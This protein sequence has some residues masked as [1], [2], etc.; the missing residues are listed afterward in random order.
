MADSDVK[1][2]GE[3]Q[4]L[5]LRITGTM[6]TNV[7]ILV[8][9]HSTVANVKSV[10]RKTLEAS[11]NRYLRLIYKG[12][13]LAP[14]T[15]RV[16]DYNVQNGDVVHAVLAAAGVRYVYCVILLSVLVVDVSRRMLHPN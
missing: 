14:D 16:K 2:D 7:E 13:L 4:F 1:Q 6:T 9:P 8:T 5:K 10:V 3:E 15:A 11:E 12:R